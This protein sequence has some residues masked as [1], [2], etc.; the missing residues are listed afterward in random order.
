MTRPWRTLIAVA[1]IGVSAGCSVRIARS[2]VVNDGPPPD[3]IASTQRLYDQYGAALSAGRRGQIANFYHFQ[4]ARIV[5]NGTQRRLSR[6]ELRQRYLTSWTPP[7]YF[8]WEGLSFD[9]LSTS[10]V[11]VTGGFLWQ[12]A[13]SRDT[14]RYI[15]AALAVAQ[16]S[17][18]A[19]VFEH[20][21]LRPAR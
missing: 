17:G 11:L 2:P 18:M 7:A 14:T 9:S 20:E 4:G 8:A 3:L 5:F 21:T 16:D 15:Y 6:D 1:A 19:I 10:Q 12:D 13:G